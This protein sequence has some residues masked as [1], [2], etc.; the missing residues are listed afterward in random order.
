M[1]AFGV[2]EASRRHATRVVRSEVAEPC[3]RRSRAHLITTSALRARVS[4]PL[5]ANRRVA[6]MRMPLSSGSVHLPARAFELAP[7]S[8]QPIGLPL[9]TLV[10]SNMLRPRGLAGR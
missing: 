9:G 5:L 2:L 3:R 1:R 4:R 7:A 8:V 10:C 6:K